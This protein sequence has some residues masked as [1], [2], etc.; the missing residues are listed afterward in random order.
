MSDRFV[1][2]NNF[3]ANLYGALRSISN[4]DGNWNI[5]AKNLLEHNRMIASN[6][7]S[8]ACQNFRKFSE[9]D[10][11]I[12]FLNCLPKELIDKFL[13]YFKDDRHEEYFARHAEMAN[14]YEYNA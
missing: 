7:Q 12:L 8:S 2:K 11:M 5:H 1:L 4:E 10:I 9:V 3:I 6:Y 14:F 13:T